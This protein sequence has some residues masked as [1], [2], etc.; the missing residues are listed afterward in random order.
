MV[1][2]KRENNRPDKRVKQTRTWGQRKTDINDV[3]FNELMLRGFDNLTFEE[4][5]FILRTLFLPKQT[6]PKE[7]EHQ[8]NIFGLEK[9]K[10]LF[11]A[12]LIAF[13]LVL[14][15][16]LLFAISFAGVFIYI[17]LKQGVLTNDGVITGL[18]GTIVEVLKILFTSG[19]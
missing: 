14:T 10:T 17:T 16:V 2:D 5:K 3:D 19:A 6:D 18:F 11:K 13:W 8:K 4:Q 1:T 15:C 12:K 9:D 7:L